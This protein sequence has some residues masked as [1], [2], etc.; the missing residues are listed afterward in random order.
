MRF[1]PSGSPLALAVVYMPK[2]RPNITP[3]E[4]IPGIVFRETI[5]GKGQI[6]VKLDSSGGDIDWS[7]SYLDGV[8]LNPDLA[9]TAVSDTRA[10]V[11]MQHVPVR[12]LG[13]DVATVV[14][15]YGL[16]AEVAY[17]RT[18]PPAASEGYSTKPFFYGVLGGDRTFDSGINVNLQFFL[19][20][21]SNYVDPRLSSADPLVRSV[22]VLGAVASQQSAA[23][24][25]GA[26]IRLSQRWLNETLEGEILGVGA[27]GTR[28][29]AL[30]MSL[31]YLVDD[32][33]KVMVGGER[34]RG[35]PDT[36]FGRLSDASTG[37]AQ[38][39]FSF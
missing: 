13:A 29:H 16:R 2:I 8:N 38:V 19:Y 36:F 20:R 35:R 9:L 21:V 7:I 24:R 31:A 25:R 6:A 12:V 15:R 17:T 10:V 27:F 32:H 18:K 34:F 22:A 39:R 37:F 5:S 4:H 14:G 28:D 1:M 3:L 23:S 30:R 26:S 11:T 33:L